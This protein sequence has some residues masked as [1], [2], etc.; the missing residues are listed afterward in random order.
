MLLTRILTPQDLNCVLLVLL[1]NAL[2]L[3]VPQLATNPARQ[4]LRTLTRSETVNNRVKE[5]Q[6]GQW[7]AAIGLSSKLS[8]P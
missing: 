5:V 4:T 1:G 3:R 8:R 7:A 6:R 2:S